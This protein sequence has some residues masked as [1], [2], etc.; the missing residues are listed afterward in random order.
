[1]FRSTAAVT[2]VSITFPLTASVCMSDRV[3]WNLQIKLNY[4]AFGLDQTEK[5]KHSLNFLIE[6]HEIQMAER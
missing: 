3:F 5:F 4:K 6:N 2:G 1:M